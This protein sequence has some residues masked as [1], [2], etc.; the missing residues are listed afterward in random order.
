MKLIWRSFGKSQDHE[1][2]SLWSRDFIGGETEVTAAGFKGGL[3]VYGAMYVRLP[4]APG[5]DCLW[6]WT[7]PAD[8]KANPND[9][10]ELLAIFVD[11]E[12]R[13]SK[14]PE[15]FLDLLVKRDQTLAFGWLLI[16]H[17]RIAVNNPCSFGCGLWCTVLRGP[18]GCTMMSQKKGSRIGL[19]CGTVLCLP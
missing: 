8:E 1:R 16:R 17:Q 2:S 3:G 13:A 12:S 15:Y 4:H 11:A 6:I 5:V 9:E 7:T 10:E 19:Q 18:G 14:T